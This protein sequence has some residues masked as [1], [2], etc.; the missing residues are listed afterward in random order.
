MC[1]K[2]WWFSSFD[3]FGTV[4]AGCYFPREKEFQ[5]PAERG[6][7]TSYTKHTSFVLCRCQVYRVNRNVM[8]YHNELGLDKHTPTITHN[9]THTHT[10]ILK[11][12][13]FFFLLFCSRE[14]GSLRGGDF[15]PLARSHGLYLSHSE[16]KKEEPVHM[17]RFCDTCLCKTKDATLSWT[18][19]SDRS[20]KVGRN[21]RSEDGNV[22]GGCMCVCHLLFSLFTLAEMFGFL[23]PFLLF[24]RS[25][26]QTNYFFSLASTLTSFDLAQVWT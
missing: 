5:F 3:L 13:Q 19:Q 11:D 20:K 22:G 17:K 7:I 23:L 25:G 1:Q 15:S 21:K 12:T 10:H 26:P 14:L 2:S 8:T 4:A 24:V 9:H 6:D 16:Q 18:G